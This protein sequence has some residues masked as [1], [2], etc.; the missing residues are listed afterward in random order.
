[1]LRVSVHDL[2]PL[3]AHSGVMGDIAAATKLTQRQVRDVLAEFDESKVDQLV[4]LIKAAKAMKI[5]AV[6]RKT[7]RER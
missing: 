7:R 5:T 2:S 1:M 4:S 6:N 3:L